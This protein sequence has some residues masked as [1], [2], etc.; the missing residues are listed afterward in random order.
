MDFL[1]VSFPSINK[2][3]K[4]AVITGADGFIGAATTNYFIEQGWQVLA[5]DLAPE[6]KRLSSQPGLTYVSWDMLNDDWSLLEPF[7]PTQGSDRYDCFIHFAWSGS[8]GELRKDLTHQMRNVRA[9][10]NCVELAKHLGCK[11]FVGAGSLMEYEVAAASHNNCALTSTNY[12][13]LAKLNAHYF[14]KHLVAQTDMKFVWGIITNVYGPGETAPRFI[15]TTLRKLLNGETLEFNS[16]GLQNY[17]FVYIDDA[18]RAF[19]GMGLYGEDNREYVLGSGSVRPLYQ[20]VIDM[21]KITNISV[22]IHFDL[23]NRVDCELDTK[24]FS[25]F[26]LETGTGWRPLYSFE[27]GIKRTMEWLKNE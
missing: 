17:D 18:A 26:E 2:F 22:P 6:P 15:N 4:K 10:E 13:G 1:N 19:Y 25:T 5:I 8:A 12:Y 27:E 7:F 23:G 24:V 14:A 21:T 11:T 9:M 16:S 3:N 20:F